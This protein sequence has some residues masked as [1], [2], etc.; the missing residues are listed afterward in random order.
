MVLCAFVCFCSGFL[1]AFIVVFLLHK[2]QLVVFYA[3]K[4]KKNAKKIY[5]PVGFPVGF[6]VDRWLFILYYLI[7]KFCQVDG[8]GSNVDR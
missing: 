4:K 2:I 3:V 6:P 5:F 1:L 8:F 7:F